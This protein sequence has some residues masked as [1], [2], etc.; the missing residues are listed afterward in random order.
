MKL[1]IQLI[2]IAL[3]TYLVLLFL[4]WWC[5]FFTAGLVGLLIPN[6]G[7]STFFAGFLGIALLWSIQA[8][9]IDLSNESILSS[10]IS[11]LFSLNSSMLLILVTALI[12]GIAGGF[13]ALTGK[14]L[15]DLFKK[16]KETYSVYT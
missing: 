16:K 1:I 12:G 9:M 15:G 3:I 5:L 2:L 13:G 10:R 6:K 4:P 14:L 8:F 7:F 11:E